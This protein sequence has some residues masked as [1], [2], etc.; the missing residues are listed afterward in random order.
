MN[1]HVV[2]D[3][4]TARLSDLDLEMIQAVPQGGNWRDIPEHLG[5]GD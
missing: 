2:T 1:E 5:R 4:Y 3:H